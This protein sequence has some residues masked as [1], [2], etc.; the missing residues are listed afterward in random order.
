MSQGR[1]VDVPLL[2]Q[3]TPL[4]GMKKE[5]QAAL[6]RKVFV[7]E[8]DAGRL[9]FKQGDTDKRTI[10]VVSGTVELREEE[11]TIGVIKGGTPEA[12]NP[13]PGKLPREFS[14]RAMDNVEYLSIDSEL[15][16]VMITWDQTGTYEVA[17]LQ[18]QIDG[19]GGD[20]WMTTLLQTKAF[21]RIPPA[22]IQAIFMRLERVPCKVG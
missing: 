1:P 4:D 18:S 2:R 13:L 21:H 3:F 17:E 20:D 15:L 5:N 10:W 12:R 14:A 16:D 22:N 11:R 8:M 19:T 6:A 9:L 7:R